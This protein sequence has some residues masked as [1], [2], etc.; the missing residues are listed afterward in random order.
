MN[1][2]RDCTAKPDVPPPTR[3]G[4]GRRVMLHSGNGLIAVVII[5]MEHGRYLVRTGQLA[6][7]QTMYAWEIASPPRAGRYCRSRIRITGRWSGS[8]SGHYLARS[9]R[10]GS[11]MF[12]PGD[13]VYVNGR[14]GTAVSY[15]G[16]FNMFAVHMDGIVPVYLLPGAGLTLDDGHAEAPFVVPAITE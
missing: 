11:N 1:I 14:L 7:P 9:L 15:D 10:A 2:K 8:D 5:G 3:Y 16:T 12:N 4:L 6:L 13:R